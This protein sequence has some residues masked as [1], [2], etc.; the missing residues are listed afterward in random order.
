MSEL[1]NCPFCGSKAILH[2]SNGLW[3]AAC[4]GM[5]CCIGLLLQSPG[6]CDYE[7]K[8]EAIEAWNRRVGE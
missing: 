1:K 3:G 6:C 7:T 4:D 5:E 8:E 2:T